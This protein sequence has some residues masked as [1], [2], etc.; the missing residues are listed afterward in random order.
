MENNSN[1]T[2]S[3]ES[4]VYTAEEVAAI[5]GVSRSTAYREIK[6][7]NAELEAQGYNTATGKISKRYFHEKS[8]L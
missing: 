8:Y 1:N 6:R 5:L 7:L 2:V 3:T 4:K